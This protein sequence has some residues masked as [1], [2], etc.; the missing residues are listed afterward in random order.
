MESKKKRKTRRL[1]VIGPVILSILLFF[2]YSVIMQPEYF[3][4]KEFIGKTFLYFFSLIIIILILGVLFILFRNFVKLIVERRRGILGSKFRT[5]LIFI[6]FIPLLVPSIALFYTAITIIQKSVE[7]LLTPPVNDITKYSS[8]IVDYFNEDLTMRSLSFAE[9][10]SGE[11][12]NGQYLDMDRRESLVQLLNAKLKECKL[13]LIVICLNDKEKFPVYDPAILE[14]GGVDRQEVTDFPEHFLASAMKGGKPEWID[15]LSK[16]YIV[17]SAVPILSSFNKA[18]A[19]GALLAGIYVRE[20]LAAKAMKIDDSRQE[21]LQMKSQKRDI[22]RIYIYIIS[23]ITLLILFSATWVGMYLTR[24]ITVPI[25]KLAEGTREISMG[26]LDFRVDV[27]AGD[28]LGML[29][30]SF[31]SMTS[32]LKASKGILEERRKYIETLL[33]NITTGVISVDVEGGVTAIN[34]A[35]MRIL[36]IEPSE[37]LIEARID[38]V[39]KG[40][41]FAKLKEYIHDVLGNEELSMSREFLFTVRGR[42]LNVAANFLSLKDGQDN[43]LGMLIV[44]EDLTQFIR[45]QKMEA[46]REVAKRIAHEIKNPLT[47]IQL[48]AQRIVKKYGEGADDLTKIIADGTSTIISQVNVLKGMVDEFSKFARM[49]AIDLVSTDPY[50]VIDSTISLYSTAHP[51]IK[52]EREYEKIAVA[53]TM[54]PDQIKRVM[55]NLIDNSIAAMQG[56]GVIT[57]AAKVISKTRRFRIEFSDNGPGIS[58]EDKDRLFIPYFSTKKVGTGLGLAIVQ[59]IITDHNGFI[60]VEDNVP[61]GAKFIIELPL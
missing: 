7:N 27:D 21:Y 26:N 30:D 37:R 16:V 38:D 11:I 14:E 22:K 57:I 29:V 23:L 48:S 24:Q 49:P 28:E 32:E 9:S 31:N 34:K 25:Q 61:T 58:S 15:R 17:R 43:Y 46:W 39:M 51:G 20:D 3:N 5:K 18:D 35:A 36:A 53:V 8:E 6:F 54:D 33:D 50:A 52:F 19:V 60:T 12:T 42:S 55:I 13:D 40:E 41:E 1:I 2:L 56:N 4:P 59:R 44:L 10:L 47:P 45:A